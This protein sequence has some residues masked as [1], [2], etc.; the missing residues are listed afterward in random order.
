MDLKIN[1]YGNKKIFIDGQE[2]DSKLEYQRYC[3]LK[4][5][6]KANEIKDL[7][8]QVC[9]EI[10]PSYRKRNKTIRAINYIADFVYIDIRT[11]QTVVE[12]TKGYRNEVYK[13][14]KKI[15]EYVYKDLEIKE[16]EKGDL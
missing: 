10:Q 12:D 3:Q 13:L 7:R 8:R 6:E 15:F 14:K 1:K 2:Y 9:F 16:I 5:L 11:G 4:L